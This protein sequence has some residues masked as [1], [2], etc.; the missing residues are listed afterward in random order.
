MALLQSPVTPTVPFLVLVEFGALGHGVPGIIISSS[1]CSWSS[2]PTVIP[3]MAGDSGGANQ[4]I[5]EISHL[6][7]KKIVDEKVS[8]LHK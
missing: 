8:T 3:I 6:K 1:Y 2:R 5:L 7:K 4:K